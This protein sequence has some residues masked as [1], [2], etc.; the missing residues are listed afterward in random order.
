VADFT[1]SHNFRL[2]LAI[3]RSEI[4]YWKFADYEPQRSR[5]IAEAFSKQ[6]GC[7]I[8]D[9]LCFGYA[10]YKDCSFRSI[11]YPYTIEAGKGINPLPVSQLDEIYG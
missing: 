10:G 3:T 4:I 9:S 1:R 8:G 11:T 2:I 5:E 6:A 7:G